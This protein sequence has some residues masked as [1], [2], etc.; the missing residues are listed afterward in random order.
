MHVKRKYV[1]KT[2]TAKE[3]TGIGTAGGGAK[4]I[5]ACAGHPFSNGDIVS[6]HGTASHDGTGLTVSEVL[7]NSFELDQAFAGVEAIGMVLH[8]ESSEELADDA[9][10]YDTA[11]LYTSVTAYTSGSV[12]VSLETSPDAG[13]TWYPLASGASISAVSKQRLEVTAPI[14]KLVRPLVTITEA[15]NLAEMSFTVHMELART[16]G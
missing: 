12:V 3:I 6:L 13:T 15:A 16:G 4:I 8:K 5:I 10:Q 11:I 1:R 2:H 7:A 9:E 14:G